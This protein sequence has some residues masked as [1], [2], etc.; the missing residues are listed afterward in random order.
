M[1]DQGAEHKPHIVAKGLM[2]LFAVVLGVIGLIYVGAGAYLASLGGSIYYVVAG[3]LFVVAAHYLFHGKRLGAWIFGGALALSV[4][5]ALWE[6]GFDWWALMPRLLIPVAFGIWLL[7]PWAQTA[8]KGKLGFATRVPAGAAGLI[9]A[10]TVVSVGLG[11]GLFAVNAPNLPQDPRFQTGMGAFPVAANGGA[12]SGQTGEDWP[13]FG[14]DQGQQKYS[15]LDQ[16]NL[17]NVSKLQ[18]AWEM[19]VGKRP[20]N[21][22]MPIKIDDTIYICN[23]NSELFSLDARTGAENWTFDASE[24]HGS[25][26]RGVTYYKAPGLTGECAERIIAG[27]G[28][29][30]LVALDAK[31]GEAC[32]DFG[33]AGFVDLLVGMEDHEGKIIGGYYKVT[34]APTFVRGKVVVGGWV[35][36]G[37]Y[38]GEASGVI[39]AFD[40]VT[41]DMSWAWDMGRP[42]EPGQPPNGESFTVATPNSWAPAAADEKLGLV[43]L[44]TGNATPDFYGAQR[45]EFDDKY[46]SSVVALDATTGRVQWSFQTKHHDI[47]D[48]DIASPPT[49]IDL[50]DSNGALRQALIQA[51]KAG[52]VFVLDRRTGEPIFDVT[53]TPMPQTGGV[54]EERISP[55][56]PYSNSLPSFRGAD[57]TEADMW[58]VSPFDQ[59]YC[60]I[61]FKQ[62]RYEGN[63]TPPGLTPSIQSPSTFG[64]INWGGVSVDPINGVMLVNNNRFASYIKL[65]DRETADGMGIEPQGEWGDPRE[66][67]GVVAQ[68]FVPYAAFPQFWLTALGVPCIDPPYGYISAVDLNTGKLLWSNTFGSSKG[69]GALGIK[70]PFELPMGTPTHGGSMITAGGLGFISAASDNIFRAYDLKTGEVVWQ[71][72]LPAAGGAPISYTLDGEQYITIM[73]GGQGAIQSRYSTKM[74]SFKLPS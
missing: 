39:R 72:E 36:D 51:T 61:M 38:W 19:P 12:A 66:V 30:K 44:P 62:A 24:G 47:W 40:A 58:G 29:A 32:S 48:H 68:K 16:I 2:W 43:Y 15:P 73:A 8:L 25:T 21:N 13:Y 59:L 34:S 14:G 56:Q 23:G 54:P 53:E 27:T 26:C 22:A 6:V 3:A 65:L 18:V 17:S 41:G 45:R 42:D 33:N 74:V 63:N 4:I 57:L 55:T 5:W 37:Q 71:Y 9:A 50:P 11:A 1:V 35:T 69:Q 31:T 20:A 52:E 28:S 7:M 70:V 46:S 60:R 67:G 10:G 64:S 49:L